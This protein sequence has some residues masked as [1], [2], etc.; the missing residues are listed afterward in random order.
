M[1]ASPWNSEEL[2]FQHSTVKQ[3]LK[4]VLVHNGI[5][6]SVKWP[7][8]LMDSTVPRV[9]GWAA[10]SVL[11]PVSHGH[12]SLQ[13]EAAEMWEVFMPVKLAW[14]WFY[15]EK[16]DQIYHRVHKGAW[17]LKSSAAM[18]WS[19]SVELALPVEKLH[20]SLD[21]ILLCYSLRISNIR[22]QTWIQN[23]CAF[24]LYA[25]SLTEVI[26][27]YFGLFLLASVTKNANHKPPKGTGSSSVHQDFS[28][29]F[30]SCLSAQ[31]LIGERG[32]YIYRDK[33]KAI[34]PGQTGLRGNFST[35]RTSPVYCVRTVTTSS[36]KNNL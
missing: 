5:V 28:M 16:T 26:G 18:T 32:W 33:A 13:T 10:A 19:I 31:L 8:F 29:Q 1:G 23:Y 30:G 36:C 7:R 2:E 20:F 15:L 4:C 3:H 21:F 35:E 12:W 24:K 11:S 9:Q 14:L 34:I 22:I 25:N 17:M 27:W 6:P